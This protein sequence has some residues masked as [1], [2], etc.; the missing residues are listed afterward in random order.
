MC[1]TASKGEAQ[2]WSVAVGCAAALCR[3]SD[4]HSTGR[5]GVGCS[6]VSTEDGAADPVTVARGAKF[7]LR[8][9]AAGVRTLSHVG[10]SVTG[11]GV[12]VGPA[13]CKLMT[14]LRPSRLRTKHGV[15]TACNNSI[16]T[17]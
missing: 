3:A 6:G 9:V 16:A 17:K 1:G 12:N 10:C 5:V 15:G 11:A 8:S 13:H 2:E 4:K 7:L 14:I